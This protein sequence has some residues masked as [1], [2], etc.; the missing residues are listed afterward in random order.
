MGRELLVI[1][2]TNHAGLR[3]LH[4]RLFRAASLPAVPITVSEL[5]R[6][7]LEHVCG[8]E[9]RVAAAVTAAAAAVA[10]AAATRSPSLGARR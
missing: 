3:P 8:D 2:P 4:E 1:A 5:P 7:H 10:I 6:D 9:R